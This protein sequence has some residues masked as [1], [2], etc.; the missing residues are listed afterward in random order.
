MVSRAARGELTM[1][2]GKDDAPEYFV[3]DPLARRLRRQ[4][5]DKSPGAG[6]VMRLDDLAAL[7]ANAE[8]FEGK[9]AKKKSARR[10]RRAL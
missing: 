1:P 6:V 8:Q 3:V 4:R 2:N 5:G 7:S 10:K 9:R